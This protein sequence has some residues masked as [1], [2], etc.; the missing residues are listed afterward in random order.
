[1]LAQC[2]HYYCVLRLLPSTLSATVS[3]QWQIG[4]IAAS[5]ALTLYFFHDF[6]AAR[7]L[8]AVAAGAHAW[9]ELPLMLLL[10][11]GSV[12][13]PPRVAS[14]SPPSGVPARCIRT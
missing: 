14:P 5:L 9:I 6:T 12:L 11:G 2:L 13:Q 8:Y 10:L 7:Q 3:R 4:A 1:M